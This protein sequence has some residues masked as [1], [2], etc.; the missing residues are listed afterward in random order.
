MKVKDVL[1]LYLQH[2][3]II[4]PLHLYINSLLNNVFKKMDEWD[5]L[6]IDK[7]FSGR[8]KCFKFF[9][10]KEI[11]DML[12]TFQHL[13]EK[14]NIKTITVFKFGD[15]N[16]DYIN[17]IADKNLIIKSIINLFGKKTK[18]FIKK[19]PSQVTFE[20]STF[21]YKGIKTGKLTGEVEE[22]FYSLKNFK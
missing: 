8:E 1:V 5:F 3:I 17:Y 12:S 4:F 15:I 2:R 14:L 6:K 11:I 19:L 9:L 18:H 21:D 10:E 13:F 22:F 7:K 16:L 20:F